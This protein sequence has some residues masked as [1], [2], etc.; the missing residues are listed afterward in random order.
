MRRILLSVLL[1]FPVSAA[2]ADAPRPVTLVTLGE[3]LF[4]P[5]REAPATVVSLNDTLISAEIAGKVEAVSRRPGDRVARNDLLAR[6]DCSNYHIARQ[7]AEAALAAARAQL[8]YARQRLKDAEKLVKKR[9]ISSDEYNQRSAEFNRLTAEVN[10]RQADLDQARWREARCEIRAPFDAVVVERRASQGDYATPGTPLLRLLDL[11]N[12][13]VSAQI[14]QQDLSAM[15]AARRLEFRLEGR[16]YPLRLRAVIPVLKKRLRSY[17]AR[18]LFTAEAAPAG[19]A[20]RLYWEEADPHLPANYLVQRGGRLGVFVHE[21][22]RA[23]FHPLPHAVQGLPARID[24]PPD[25]RLIDAGRF[26]VRDGEPVEVVE[27]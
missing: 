4:H 16:R 15:K 7:R 5:A 27:P 23:R 19:A 26:S 13:E 10:V 9:N 14:Q 20:G 12:L 24:L 18:Y 6:L 3:L 1:W 17:E 8:R 11:E 2:T 21:G 25:T 22:G